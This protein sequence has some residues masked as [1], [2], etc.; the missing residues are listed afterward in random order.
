MRSKILPNF[1]LGVEPIEDGSTIM[2]PGF[3]GIE[4]ELF[5][6]DNNY[7]VFGDAKNSVSQIVETLKED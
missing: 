1:K 5:G 2:I 3:A 7:M 6:Y 4:N